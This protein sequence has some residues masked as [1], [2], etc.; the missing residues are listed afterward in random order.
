MTY[1]I[2]AGD[3]DATH[4]AAKQ[5]FAGESQVITDSAPALANIAQYEVC[6]LSAAGVTPYVVATHGALI[7]DKLVVAQIAVTSGQQCPYYSAGKFNHAVLKWPA[8]IDTYAKRRELLQG[9]M[10]QVGHLI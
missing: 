7:P 9:S 5:L 3:E 8:T 1:P 2:L 4:A 6:V 10:L